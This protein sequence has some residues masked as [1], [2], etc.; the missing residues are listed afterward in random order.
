MSASTA[1]TRATRAYGAYDEESASLNGTTVPIVT[2]EDTANGPKVLAHQVGSPA[3]ARAV[4]TDAARGHDL[5]GVGTDNIVQ[6]VGNPTDPEFGS[7]WALNPQKTSYL[8]A[9]N[10]SKGA[11]ITVA[12]VDTGVAANH[13]DRLD[14]P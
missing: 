12:V 9:W 5:V 2:V 7:Q 1:A 11:G 4:A 6:P 8:N 14:R 13:P 3:Q 10:T